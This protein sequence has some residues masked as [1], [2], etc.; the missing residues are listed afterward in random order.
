MSE[1]Q[2]Q[3]SPRWMDAPGLTSFEF[4][5]EENVASMAEL[6]IF[7]GGMP[8]TRSEQS[9]NSAVDI[10]VKDRVLLPAHALGIWLGWNFYR[11]LYEPSRDAPDIS[12]SFSHEM[13]NVGEGYIWPTIA[14]YSDG[15]RTVLH[16]KVLDVPSADW[17]RYTASVPVVMP[18]EHFRESVWEFLSVCIERLNEK[19]CKGSPLHALYADLQ[20]ES[21]DKE[22]LAWRKLEALMGFN[23]GRAP[24]ILFE[25][26]QSLESFLGMEALEEFAASGAKSLVTKEQFCGWIRESGEDRNFRDAAQADVDQVDF[27]KP[28]WLAARESADACRAQWKL[29]GDSVDNVRLAELYGVNKRLFTNRS[30]SENLPASFYSRA[31]SKV[32]IQRRNEAGRRFAV[33]RLIG[34]EVLTH[35][36]GQFSVAAESKTYR[37]KF[38]RAFAAELLCPAERLLDY[39]GNN[40]NDEEKIVEAAEYFHVSEQVVGNILK[41]NGEKD[42]IDRCA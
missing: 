24:E 17:I 9:A 11:L 31:E 36:T 38:Q 29:G 28:A 35:A 23:P 26:A 12:W 14:I 8:L 21:Q 10:V 27:S 13:T 18:T 7:F 39:L 16:P 37:Q 40:V 25:T 3:F 34:D 6:G 33:A 5:S 41:N 22:A 4:E 42:S 20:E 30:I 2:L 1:T 32:V 15:K 19:H